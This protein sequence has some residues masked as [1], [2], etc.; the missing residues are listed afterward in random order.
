VT[1]GQIRLQSQKWGPGI[2][3]DL[4][5]QF[6]TGR[7][8]MILDA[9]PWKAL[10]TPGTISTTVGTAGARAL[11]KLPADLKILLEVNN[12]VGNFPMRPYTQ[13]EMNL[14]YPGRL[15]LALTGNAPGTFIYSMAE[16]DNSSPPLHQVELYPIPNAIVSHPIRYIVNPPTFNPQQ[17]TLSPLPW[18]PSQVLINGIRAD[19]CA[20]LKD[21]NGMNAFEVLF[22]T[23]LNEM[24]RVELHR[25]PT[26]RGNEQDR[27]LGPARFPPP[28][29]ISRSGDAGN[30]RP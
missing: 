25:Q 1:F 24:L 15:D 5:D 12:S 20:Y 28:P 18:I 17:T 4:L 14:L 3:L 6:I 11:Y 22:T 23:G 21:Y 13:Q 26:S 16:D 29:G 27:Y 10:E 30:G 7:Y 19:I 8:S 9:H 2:D